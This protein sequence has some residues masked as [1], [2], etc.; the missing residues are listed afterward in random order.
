MMIR[1]ALVKRGIN[2]QF[3]IQTF[4]FGIVGVMNTI[5]GYG[6]YYILV[7]L[8]LYYLVASIL[9][10]VVGVINSYFWNKY[11]TF[12]S[13]KKSK[14]EAVRF[15]TVYVVQFLLNLGLLRVMVE[16]MNIGKE[17]A[18]FYALLIV[19]GVSFLGHKFFSFRKDCNK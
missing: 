13:K 15:V 6:T 17:V 8:N 19:T 4:K 11:W 9:S 5:I 16:F 2:R 14:S 10:T 3:I 1:E 12:N 7:K 18:G